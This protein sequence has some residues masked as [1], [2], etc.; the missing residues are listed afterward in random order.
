MSILPTTASL[1]E[2]AEFSARLHG[3]R[4]RTWKDARIL[5]VNPVECGESEVEWL[6][7]D[8][9]IQVS[10]VVQSELRRHNIVNQHYDKKEHNGSNSW[11]V[12]KTDMNR[13]IYQLKQAFP[14]KR[15]EAV[16]LDHYSLQTTATLSK[17][18]L[19]AEQ[20][21][22]PNPDPLFRQFA[23]PDRLKQATVTC[24]TL[25]Q[26]ETRQDTE[27]EDCVG[28][29]DVMADFC[30]T[31]EGNSWC[32]PTADLNLMFRKTLLAKSNGILWVTFSRPMFTK[33]SSAE[34]ST[35][36]RN[37]LRQTAMQFDYIL[38]TVRDVCYGNMVTQVYMTGRQHIQTDFSKFV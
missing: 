27:D 34:I 13:L 37:W 22:V 31:F 29:F 25:F 7:D 15:Q 38:S 3:I 20:I 26:W 28:L 36:I 2:W 5:S 21:H 19:S 4:A 1:A 8:N 10:L 33:N 35:R 16:V 14:R 18:G 6:D 17:C 32:S 24:E 30:C 12:K 11:D 23:V 9:N